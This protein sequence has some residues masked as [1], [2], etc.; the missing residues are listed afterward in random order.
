MPNAKYSIEFYMLDEAFR[1]QRL[2]DHVRFVPSQHG[3]LF[4]PGLG[5]GEGVGKPPFGRTVLGCIDAEFDD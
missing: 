1:I 3:C 5:R 4:D 2:V